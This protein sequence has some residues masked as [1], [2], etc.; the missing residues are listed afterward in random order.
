MTYY[1]LSKRHGD[2]NILRHV[3]DSPFDAAADAGLLIRRRLPAFEGSVNCRTQIDAGER[4]VVLWTAIVELSPVNE[5]S[6]T[7]EKKEVRSA[8]R[9]ESLSDALRFVDEI[10]E[11]ISGLGH[12]FS[13]SIPVIIGECHRIVR[14]DRDNGQT[15]FLVLGREAG[16]FIPD[17]PDD[18][19]VR[20]DKNNKQC[21]VP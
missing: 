20:T 13:H 5:Y 15:L 18:G 3:P 7:V 21:T 14:I 11:G 19:T 2:G 6:I 17:M 1:G 8:S 10:G 12:L 16:K 4:D 9:S